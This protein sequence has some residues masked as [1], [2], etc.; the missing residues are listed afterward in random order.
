MLTSVCMRSCRDSINCYQPS[1]T[2]GFVTVSGTVWGRLG[3]GYQGPSLSPCQVQ[4]ACPRLERTAALR[5]SCGVCF[6]PTFAINSEKMSKSC[7]RHASAPT[8]TVLRV[9]SSGS[10][11][12]SA[13]ASPHASVW[14]S[15]LSCGPA[16]GRGRMS[17]RPS[18]RQNLVEPSPLRPVSR[19][20]AETAKKAADLGEGT[21][22][23]CE[24]RRIGPPGKWLCKP[25]VA[26]S[27]PAGSIR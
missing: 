15:R 21:D 16:E 8:D 12:G 11:R 14:C 20:V 7:W 9:L 27:I 19:R 6:Q 17:M 18:D 5:R 24:V 3:E 26:G 1:S 25:E 22:S 13:R 4:G 23:L 10:E 2:V